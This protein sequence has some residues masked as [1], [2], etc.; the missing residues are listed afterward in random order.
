[1]ESDAEV[2]C[3]RLNVL[4]SMKEFNVNI[5]KDCEYDPQPVSSRQ[6]QAHPAWE[7]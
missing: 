5:C 7:M 6:D 1:M 2:P 3:M 4:V